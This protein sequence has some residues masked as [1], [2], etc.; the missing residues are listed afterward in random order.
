MVKKIFKIAAYITGTL[1]MVILF[2]IFLAGSGLLNGFIVRTIENV[3]A[4]ET[5]GRLEIGTMKGEILSG[6]T[7][8]NVRLF[9]GNDTLMQCDEISAEYFLRNILKK[10]IEV[11]KVSIKNMSVGLK[12][13]I[14]STWNFSGLM[15]PSAPEDT[16]QTKTE[17]SDWTF[18]LDDLTI[19]NFNA[20][21]DAI[22]TG[23]MIPSSVNS[24]LSLN[25]SYSSDSVSV[26]LKS[27]N[28]RT[29]KPAFEIVNLSGL[30][31]K[32]DES[33]SWKNLDLNLKKTNASSDGKY[34]LEGNY[35]EYFTILFDSLAIDDFRQL[36]PGLKIFGTPV[37]SA[38]LEGTGEKYTF[39]LSLNEANQSVKINGEIS[40]YTKA[41]VYSVN[42]FAQNFD[43][44]TW[45]HNL[46]MKSDITGNMSISGNGLDIKTNNM[47]VEGQFGHIAYNGQELKGLKFDAVKKRDAVSGSIK[48]GTPVGN[49]DLDFDL[50]NV[51][52][53]PSYN[54]SGLI[55]HLDLDKVPGID[56]IYSDLNIR[57]NAKG[58]GT[59]PAKL[60]A[61]L[62]MN[63][64][65]SSIMSIPMENFDLVA[66]YNRGDYNF[67]LSD[68]VTPYF[69][70]SAKGEGNLKKN[71]DARFS[72]STTGMDTVF[73]MAGLPP[74][75]I[76]GDIG[77]TIS[78][79]SDS[80][81][82][83]IN[84]NLKDIFYDSVT[85][86]NLN[87]NADIIFRGNKYSGAAYV[88]SEGLAYKEYK[89]RNAE[90]NSGFSEN[91]IDADIR[92]VANDSLSADFSGSVTG[93]ENPLLGIRYLGLN[94]N[95]STWS[96]GT[97]SATISLNEDNISI[98]NFSLQSGKQSITVDGKFAMKG[99]E[100]LDLVISQLD[101]EKLPFR[102]FLPYEISGIVSANIGLKG[103]SENPLINGN[104]VAKNIGMGDFMADSIRS[105]LNYGSDM[106]TY[107]AV[108][109]PAQGVPININLV[110]PAHVSLSDSISVLKDQPGFSASLLIDSLDL[111]EIS[112][113]IPLKNTTVRGNAHVSLEA[114]NTL[115][116]PVL[117]GALR[118]R[119]GSYKNTGIGADY[120]NIQFSANIRDSVVNIEG[121]TAR[122]RKGSIDLSGYVSLRNL[123]SPEMNRLDLALKSN[124]FQ[125]LESNAMELNFNSD[126]KLTGSISKPEFGGNITVNRSKLNI[127]YL[128]ESMSQKNDNPDLP[129]LTQAIADT[130]P[131]KARV[132]RDTSKVSSAF[133][134]EE[135][136]KNLTGEAVV[137]IPGNTWITGKDMN[138][139]IEGTVRA[140]KAAEGISLF[141]DLN[142]KRG[143]YKIYGRSFEFNKGVITFTGGSQMNPEVDFEIVY[144]FRDI[145]KDLRQLRLLITGKMLQPQI[146]FMLDDQSI[147]E[148]DAISYIIFGRS[149][150]QLGE[151]ER[152]KMS[153]ENLALGTAF[154][155]LS[156]VVKD[157]LQ[158]S[159]G[160][161][162]F[163]VS[164]GENWKSGNVTIG[165]YITNKLFLSYERSFDFDKQSKTPDTERIMLDYQ[166]LRNL[167]LKATNQKINS[168][169]DLI[170][171]KTWR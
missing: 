127:D 118:L 21:I 5:N 78:G 43:A 119:N 150:N 145:A 48:S 163:E 114:K 4:K 147:E 142:I 61:D 31:R 6:F 11:G 128:G 129:L 93:F 84:F 44:S 82:A 87:G 27:L 94:Y 109:N 18:L 102:K 46:E 83:V 132:V 76:S 158:E 85:V 28:L 152:E 95:K 34:S 36:L 161:D 157:V 166:I 42:M 32:D 9:L 51:F 149:V 105:G 110:L 104:L 49:A 122:T 66:G 54:I 33:A 167:I 91:M 133:P 108:I 138:F 53:N 168:G 96:T 47:T 100:S 112:S 81:D 20:S 45:T 57:L 3:A 40:D 155:Q 10:K 65:N 75:K 124:N 77:G 12:Q 72:F 162:V 15:N 13:D 73:K 101:L 156:S 154:T 7:L 24:N 86:K 144:K 106:L 16:T 151:G 141:G 135:I 131:E 63:V 38:S 130:L 55:Q 59:D 170:F 71:N 115:N 67:D 103:T 159:A 117:T 140:V 160:I 26:R 126:L 165:K 137:D 74:V 153:S 69:S 121:L 58:H 89:I 60:S 125:L 139:E 41:P 25:G 120:R 111:Q 146:S 143:Y 62:D 88:N 70:F 8:E 92:V 148:K 79:T 123:N 90:I 14:D 23:S 39:K 97:D 19:E 68:I 29:R 37:V 107:S 56:S 136:Y 22:D 64:A 169:F 99:S 134:G 98:T 116:Q 2:I 1:L 80:L 52:T 171:K 30:F 164:G 35:F 50:G 113:F 17:P